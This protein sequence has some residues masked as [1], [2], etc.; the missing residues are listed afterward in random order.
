MTCCVV[1]ADITVTERQLLNDVGV[2]FNGVAM[3]DAPIASARSMY[4]SVNERINDFGNTCMRSVAW[5]AQNEM[6]PIIV[7]V[8]IDC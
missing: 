1:D 6:I 7:L 8:I 4:T 3:L 5:S 2:N